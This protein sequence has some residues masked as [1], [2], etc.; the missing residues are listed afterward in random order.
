[1]HRI[2]SSNDI[3][4]LDEVVGMTVMEGVSLLCA[5]RR[6]LGITQADMG[7]R[8]GVSQ[9]A[10]KQAEDPNSKPQRKTLEK[11]AKALDLP[12]DALTLDD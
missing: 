7:K 10:V 2:K 1:M 8:M 11:W 9:S 6:H 12:I 3:L 5:W 4:I